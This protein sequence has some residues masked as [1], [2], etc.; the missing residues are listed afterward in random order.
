MKK[1]IF[2]IMALSGLLTATSADAQLQKGTFLIGGQLANINFGLGSSNDFNLAITP[3]AGYFIENNLAV[4]LEVPLHFEAVKGKDPL[5][6]Y[7]IGA[8]GRYY[9]APKEFNIDNI[10]NHGRFFGEA[11]LG[12]AGRTNVDV[13]FN[14]KVGAGYAY[15]IT[16]NVALEAMVR[17][18][19]TYGS[20]SSSGLGINLGFQIHLPSN[21]IK[22]E[23]Y[24]I[25]KD[26]NSKRMNS[27]DNEE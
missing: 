11:G 2:S 7:G 13:G 4:G 19:G 18:E 23:Y 24:D 20:G 14:I 22:S 1:L 3:K 17:Y 16:P 12:I 9:V 25:K 5:F 6:R 8:F 26:V 27:N 10:L 21:K 15:F